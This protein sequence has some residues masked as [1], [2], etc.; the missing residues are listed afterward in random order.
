MAIE[1]YLFR[2]IAG[3][4]FSVGLD[5]LEEKLKASGI[6]AETNPYGNWLKVYY[7][8][9][10]RGTKEVAFIG[11]SMGALSA[12]SLTE[13]LRSSGVKVMYLGL[14][15]IPGPRISAPTNASWSESYV[16]SQPGFSLLKQNKRAQ[17]LVINTRVPST[18]HITIDDS[19]RVHDAIISA[20][21]LAEAS[22]KPASSVLTAYA[23]AE[24]TRTTNLDYMTTSALK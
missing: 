21:W 24:E 7:Q 2:G 20:V 14:I 16:S 23:P 3:V 13:K 15:D 9:M 18:V 11:H 8:I 6:R 19:E 4:P 10:R 5:D 12:V 1:V 22:L 17:N